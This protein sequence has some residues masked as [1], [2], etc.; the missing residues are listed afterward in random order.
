MKRWIGV[1]FIMAL[2][3]TWI[4]CG[5]KNIGKISGA[6]NDCITIDNVKYNRETQHNFSNADKGKYLGKVSNAKITMR[7]YSVKGDTA[8]EY[9]YALWEWEGSFYKRE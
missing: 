3:L 9:I 5:G 1:A 2:L 4:V 7:V 8:G 6:E